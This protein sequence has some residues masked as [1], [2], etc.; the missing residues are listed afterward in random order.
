MQID[1]AN[2]PNAYFTTER[3]RAM[4]RRKNN[5]KKKQTRPEEGGPRVIKQKFS[6]EEEAKDR[7]GSEQRCFTGVTILE[8]SFTV[9]I[10]RR[11]VLGS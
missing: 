11:P 6:R 7:R 1:V 9:Q 8:I 5:W 3:S 4:A 2:E 10:S